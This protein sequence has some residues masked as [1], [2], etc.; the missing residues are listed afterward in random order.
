[1]RPLES[2]NQEVV[3]KNQLGISEKDLEMEGMGRT[4]KNVLKHCAPQKELIS[5]EG[6]RGRRRVRL[7]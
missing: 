3:A 5:G 7:D 6:D 2:R 4:T 1:M